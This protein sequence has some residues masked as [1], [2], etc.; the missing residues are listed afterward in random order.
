MR[1]VDFGTVQTVSYQML[2]PCGFWT[3]R[4]RKEVCGLRGQIILDQIDLAAHKLLES[5]EFR[6][7]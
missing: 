5:F 7:N 2:E 1:I 4:L 6:I 3:E